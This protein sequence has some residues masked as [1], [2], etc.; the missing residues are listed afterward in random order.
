MNP[1][2]ARTAF[3]EH[4]DILPPTPAEGIDSMF[5]SYRSASADGCDISSDGDMLL[6]PWGTFDWG[7]G[8]YFEIDVTRQFM[9]G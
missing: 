3:E 8:D 7:D 2:R 6:F 5:S 1:K 4:V 9:R